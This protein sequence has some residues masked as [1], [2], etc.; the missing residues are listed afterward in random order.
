MTSQ[1]GFHNA[2]RNWNWSLTRVVARK[3]LTV[4]MSAKFEISGN[5]ERQTSN[6]GST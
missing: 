4:V 1:T 6:F 5:A 2:G 3:A